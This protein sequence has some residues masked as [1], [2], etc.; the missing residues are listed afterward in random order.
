MRPDAYFPDLNGSSA[1][2]DIGG[3]SKITDIKKYDGLADIIA[4]ILH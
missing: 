4:P 3:V 1:I 2:F